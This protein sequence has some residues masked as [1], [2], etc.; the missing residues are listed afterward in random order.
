MTPPDVCRHS[1][2]LSLPLPR[3]VSVPRP[4]GVASMP[5]L[6][7]QSDALSNAAT[8]KPDSESRISQ[9][10]LADGRAVFWGRRANA[11]IG[12]ALGTAPPAAASRP[13]FFIRMIAVMIITI[14]Y[15]Q[16][17]R[18]ADYLAAYES[19]SS[20]PRSTSAEGATESPSS[21]SIS[22]RS[23]LSPGGYLR[24]LAAAGGKNCANIS[25]LAILLPRGVPIDP[26]NAVAID[27]G[28]QSMKRISNT[29]PCVRGPN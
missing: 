23:Y 8:G 20:R 12:L 24:S 25:R 26:A 2:S 16:P 13:A 7:G 19:R 10:L 18:R 4:I 3:C 11:A 1:L 6:R 27:A 5:S 14:T 22:A 21:S 17:V 15:H 9:T 28:L 29:F